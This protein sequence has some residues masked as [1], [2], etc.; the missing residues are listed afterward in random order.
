M[1]GQTQLARCFVDVLGCDQTRER[2]H[3]AL[4]GV[5]AGGIARSHERRDGADRHDRSAAAVA[6]HAERVLQR[7]ERP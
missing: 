6:E 3:A 5:V 4:G 1:P 7:Q 2:K